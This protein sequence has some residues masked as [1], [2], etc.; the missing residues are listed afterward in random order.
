MIQMHSFD[1][2]KVKLQ[3]FLQLNQA[4]SFEIVEVSGSQSYS[5][6]VTGASWVQFL[7][8][9]NKDRQLMPFCTKAFNLAP[10]NLQ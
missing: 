8:Q 7:N 4:F 2:I 5:S 9:E 1:A 10:L 6:M 3:F